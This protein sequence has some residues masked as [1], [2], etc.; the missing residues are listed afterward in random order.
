MKQ[1][2][3]SKPLYDRATFF[4]KI[5]F[6]LFVINTTAAVT[7]LLVP[8][9]CP[10]MLFWVQLF[11]AS[12][13]VIDTI[14]TDGWLWFTAEQS[15]RTD[16]IS[17]GFGVNLSEK[18]SEKYYDNPF[19]PSLHRYAVNIFESAFYSKSIAGEMMLGLLAKALIVISVFAFS[20]G[21]LG[22]GDMSL[23]IAQTCFS[24]IFLTDTIMAGVFCRRVTSI[25]DRLYTALVTDGWSDA[26]QYQAKILA[27]AIEYEA[28]KAFY[29][30]RLSSRIKNKNE[31]ALVQKWKETLET[32]KAS[33]TQDA[34][35]SISPKGDQ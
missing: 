3:D 11:T 4:D 2:D 13:Y 5:G 25:H 1:R 16:C 35:V 17:N 19:P 30:V 14:G 10:E 34:T 15:R 6:F 12:G 32:L 20:L 29:K 18:R 33:S 8:G 9:L 26:S 24:T 31:A 21:K 7:A 27:Y 28:L 22:K 23:L